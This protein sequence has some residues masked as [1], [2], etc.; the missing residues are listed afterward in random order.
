MSAGKDPLTEV[1]R[2]IDELEAFAEKP[3]PFWKPNHILVR[4]ED[5][6]R[7]TQRLREALPG[8]LVEARST[9][10]KR[11]LILRNA[12]EEHKRILDTAERR[13]E[14]LISDEQVVI[15]AQREAERCWRTWKSSSSRRW[16]RSRRAGV[17]SRRSWPA[18][19]RPPSTAPPRPEQQ[20]PNICCCV[21]A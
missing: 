14:D 10:E 3:S 2:L 6:F 15:A 21:H 18:A 5:F 13:L 12:Q 11:D 9:L 7:I 1:E 19:A 8:E 16:R 4:D 17:S 20:R